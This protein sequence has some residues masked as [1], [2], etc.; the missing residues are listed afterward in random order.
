M[1]LEEIKAEYPYLY[2]THMH[3]SEGSKCGLNTAAEMVRAYKEYGYTGVI[4]TDHNWHGNTAVDRS[5]PWEEWL[6]T[7]FMGY[8]NAKAEGDK[9]GLDVFL[10]YEAGYGGPEF[11]ITGFTIDD[12][13]KHPEIKDASVEEQ[14]KL[15]H[16]FG[17]M[18]IQAH[19]YRE[20]SY[21]KEVITYEKFVD[22]IEIIN[23]SH[24][25]PKDNSRNKCIFDEKATKLAHDNNLPC[26]AGS[27]QHW[28][29]GLMGGGI[30]F[31]TPLTSIQDYIKRIKNREDYVLT[32]GRQWFT[33]EGTL[34]LTCKE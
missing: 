31:K 27:D 8:H 32:N 7:F 6:D 21:I 5:L 14:L 25:N 15:I 4:I 18:V 30:A 34:L 28:T 3:T 17:G 26:T 10:G 12:L 22:G 13:K 11:L 1:T 24:S 23:A 29:D 19:P 2:E 9:I 33:K 16:S 20:A